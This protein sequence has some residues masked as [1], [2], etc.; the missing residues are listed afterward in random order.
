MTLT[1]EAVR[2]PGVDPAQAPSPILPG[3]LWQG[4]CPVDFEWV[5]QTGID[6]VV[7]VADAHAHPPQGAV[8]GLTY[9]KCP[10]VDGDEVPDP[11]VTLRLA[12]LVAELLASGHRV[13]VH[14]TFGRNRSGLLVALIVREVL[15]V[16]GDDAV[17]HVQ[18]C[19]DRALNNKA[20]AAWLRSLP[21]P[22]DS[23]RT[24]ETGAP[25]S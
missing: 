17:R 4:G 2:L 8:D 23:P 25:P 15:G 9:L 11:A 13:L 12:R 5:R 10:L 1:T 7:D 24:A 14:C 6:V 18:A 16:D 3:R 21:A 22:E 20:F 19:R